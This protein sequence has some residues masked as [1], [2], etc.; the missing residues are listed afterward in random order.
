MVPFDGG[1]GSHSDD[2]FCKILLALGHEFKG[3]SH[4]RHFSTPGPLSLFQMSLTL[5]DTGVLPGLLTVIV[6]P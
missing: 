2:M 5:L 6:D 4:S 1:S 3:V